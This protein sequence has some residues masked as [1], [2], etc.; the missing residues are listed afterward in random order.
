MRLFK[1]D[2]ILDPPLS[3]LLNFIKIK[4]QLNRMMGQK[5]PE[6]LSKP[7]KRIRLKKGRLTLK[8]HAL[9]RPVYFT[10]MKI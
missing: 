7:T 4:I 10:I 2:M 5:I 8:T 3:V 6:A 9:S 1:K